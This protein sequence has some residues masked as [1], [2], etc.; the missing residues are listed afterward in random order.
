[1]AS[2]L[3][4]SPGHTTPDAAPH[5]QPAVVAHDG[6]Q[7]AVVRDGRGNVEGVPGDPVQTLQ[8]RV[9]L[10]YA[11][12]LQDPLIMDL[13]PPG[14]DPLHGH[15]ADEAI[16]DM[17]NGSYADGSPKW[18]FVN[19]APDGG[20]IVGDARYPISHDPLPPGLAIDRFG[21]PGGRFASPDTVPYPSRGLP[22]ES[23]GSEYHR[24][25]VVREIPG[26]LVETSFIE[27]AFYETRGI[28]PGVQYTFTVS[29]SELV[30]R[31][32]LSIVQPAHLR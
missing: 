25:Q 5:D 14:Y 8:R 3:T 12:N 21:D 27:K 15:A 32:Y 7:P 10:G 6:G 28:P 2:W 24:Y 19:Q 11:E 17:S 4:G 16:R 30:D 22:P 1:M 23:A 9:D 18:D 31:G 13:F 29:I 20:K 26:N